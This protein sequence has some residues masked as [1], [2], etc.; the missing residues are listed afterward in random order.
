MTFFFLVA[1]SL[2]L[3]FGAVSQWKGRLWK[4]QFPSRLCLQPPTPLPQQSTPIRAAVGQR[5][6]SSGRLHVARTGGFQLVCL[7]ERSSSWSPYCKQLGQFSLSKCRVADLLN[8]HPDQI[9]WLKDPYNVWAWFSNR[10]ELEIQECSQIIWK[11]LAECERVEGFA[12]CATASAL[13][14]PCQSRH[15][16]TSSESQGKHNALSNSK[17]FSEGRNGQSLFN[18]APETLWSTT[19]HQSVTGQECQS[20]S[21]KNHAFLPRLTAVL[22]GRSHGRIAL[23]QGEKCTTFFCSRS[24]TFSDRQAVSEFDSLA[25]AKF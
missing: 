8:R 12:L 6:K 21:R 22:L 20:A 19:F 24:K 23:F 11:W 2:S 5:A 13:P 16:T 7:S 3:L 18:A 9:L 15:K 25:F 10:V 1:R 4:R 14:L 17:F